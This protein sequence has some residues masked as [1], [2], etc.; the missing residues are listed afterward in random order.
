MAAAEA[1]AFVEIAPEPAGDLFKI[2]LVQFCTSGHCAEQNQPLGVKPGRTN[3][4]PKPSV[5]AAMISIAC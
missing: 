4:M 3:R 5:R 2:A 1:F